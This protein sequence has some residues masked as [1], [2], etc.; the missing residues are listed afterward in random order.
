VHVRR[1]LRQ[2]IIDAWK[3]CKYEAL[4]ALGQSLKHLF[5]ATCPPIC[6]TLR[7]RWCGPDYARALLRA[8]MAL[9]KAEP[10]A[11]Q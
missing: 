2:V 8:V 7:L 3:V 5:A 10:P 1:P 6:Y 9:T 11:A 4:F